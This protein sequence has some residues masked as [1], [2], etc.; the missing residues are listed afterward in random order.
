MNRLVRSLIAVLAGVGLV[1]I[2]VEVLEFMLVNAYAGA[3]IANMDTYMAIRNEPVLMAA[4][5]GY[6]TLASLLGGDVTARIAA[7]EELPHGLLAA[8]VK[9][10]ALI[11]GFTMDEFAALTP[12]WMRVALLATTGPA[13]IAGAW[14]RAR[15]A[16]LRS[17]T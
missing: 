1:S 7:G 10:A 4:K 14:V 6:N 8:A 2:I 5:L 17:D 16:S 15:A 9:S 12:V 3:R 11:W 13:M